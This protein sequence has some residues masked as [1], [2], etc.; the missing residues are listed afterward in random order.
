MTASSRRQK[1]DIQKFMQVLDKPVWNALLGI[2]KHRGITVQEL[3]RAVVIPEW[4]EIGNY[5]V[6]VVTRPIYKSRERRR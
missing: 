5:T 6:K 4:R 3:L 2:A 1:K